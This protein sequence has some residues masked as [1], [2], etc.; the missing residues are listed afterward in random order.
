MSLSGLGEFPA[1]LPPEE[2]TDSI[3]TIER[4]LWDTPLWFLLI[5]AFAGTEWFLRRKDNLV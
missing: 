5:V 4:E 1:S 2:T 3:I